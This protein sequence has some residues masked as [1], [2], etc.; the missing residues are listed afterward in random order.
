M[1]TLN[2]YKNPKQYHK[3]QI[4][5]LQRKVDNINLEIA[6]HKETLR[7]LEAQNENNKL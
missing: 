6:A 1:K 7:F 3:E 2:D 5:R 4:E